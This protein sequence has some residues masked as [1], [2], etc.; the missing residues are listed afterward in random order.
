MV[1]VAVDLELEGTVKEGEGL[2]STDG[3]DWG[4]F[5]EEQAENNAIQNR[6]GYIHFFITGLILFR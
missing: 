5:G 6:R 2:T 4:C 3:V 1:A